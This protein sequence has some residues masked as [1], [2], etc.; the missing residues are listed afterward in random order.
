MG[1]DGGFEICTPE[2]QDIEKSWDGLSQ[3]L[4]EL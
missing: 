2:N 4:R 3:I 1:F